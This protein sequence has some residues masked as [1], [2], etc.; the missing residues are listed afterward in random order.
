LSIEHRQQDISS[1]HINLLL[2]CPEHPECHIDSNAK[3]KEKVG[4]GESDGEGP[5]FLLIRW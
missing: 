5:P 2:V 4:R 1:N 3:G